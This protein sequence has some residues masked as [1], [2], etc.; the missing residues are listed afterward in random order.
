MHYRND[1]CS[2]LPVS[3]VDEFLQGKTGVSRLDTG[4]I[5]FKMTEL[6]TTTQIIVLEPA[7]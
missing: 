4:E 6:A 2:S 1:R 5:E 3:E 7:L